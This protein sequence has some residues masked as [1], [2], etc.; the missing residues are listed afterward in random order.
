MTGLVAVVGSANLD[1]VLSVPRRPLAGETVLGTGYTETPGG[2]GA[3][4]AIAA[5]RVA[6]C[7]MIGRVG[8][9]PAGAR[10]IDAVAGAG[11]DTDGLERGEQPTG[12]AIITLTP[13]GENSIVVLPLAN[14]TMD[15]LTAMA[16]LERRRPDVVLT[17]LEIRLAVVEAVARWS[18]RAGARFLLNPSPAVPIPPAL[19]AAA[20]PLI[21]NVGEAVALTGRDRVPPSTLARLLA[22]R[23]RSV[24]VTAGADGAYVA[25]AGAVAHAEAVTV[26]RAVD[27]TGAGDV[28]AGTVAGHLANGVSLVEAS[29]RANAEAARIVQLHRADR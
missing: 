20:D 2:K 4:Q 26:A 29:R 17:Q 21:L 22:D 25:Q 11:V 16:H 13:D 27:T 12:R 6:R 9:D 23:A 10:L 28:F 7:A 1:I 3:N 24:V 15:E 19:V 8:S 14:S 5:A 18:A